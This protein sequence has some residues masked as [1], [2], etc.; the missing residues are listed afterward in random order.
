MILVKRVCV[1]SADGFFSPFVKGRSVMAKSGTT[2][3]RAATAAS[4]VMTD[5][6]SGKN[7]KTAAASALSQA[8]K[9]GNK[10]K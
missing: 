10:K 4:K 5:G 1:L 9:G 6:R 7:A 2:G 8:N 3:K